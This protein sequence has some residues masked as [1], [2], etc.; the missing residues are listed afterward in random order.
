MLLDPNAPT[1]AAETG[2]RAALYPNPASATQRLEYEVKKS[3]PVK[4]EVLD[5]Q[6]Q[7]LR[8]VLNE[9]QEPG[10]HTLDV[11][12]A[13]LQ[14]GTYLYKITTRGGTESRRFVKE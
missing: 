13:D 11:N 7:T 2:T 5:Q 8:T 3:G 4:I 10:Q 9:K 1:N 14:R 6:G 12:V